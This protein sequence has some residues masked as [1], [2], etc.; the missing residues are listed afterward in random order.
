MKSAIILIVCCIFS[1]IP[2]YKSQQYVCSSLEQGIDFKGNDLTFTYDAKNAQGCANICS[3]LSKTCT[4]FT[5]WTVSA[6]SSICFLK[7]FTTTPNRFP[8]KNRQS[9]IMVRQGGAS[10]ASSS[11]S[12]T[13]FSTLSSSTTTTFFST[14]TPSTTTTTTTT[15]GTG[16]TDAPKC[17][18]EPNSYYGDAL[19]A[20]DFRNSNSFGEC[21]DLCAASQGQCAE[22]SFLE[23]NFICY[24]YSNPLPAKQFRALTT[25]GRLNVVAKFSFNKYFKN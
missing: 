16:P 25:G 4:G 1:L 11:S 17:L 5:F 10:T 3:I 24:I 13:I 22:F 14:D 12:T 2:L 20:Y 21:C 7:N 9:C 15:T 6:T 18:T 19:V 23:D 8:A